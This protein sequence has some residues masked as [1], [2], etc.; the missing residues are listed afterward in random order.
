MRSLYEPGDLDAI[1]QDVYT[2][3]LLFE[4]SGDAS[5]ENLNNREWNE[6]AA[7]VKNTHSERMSSI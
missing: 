3:K 2:M 7:K 4:R 5:A 6:E 1:E